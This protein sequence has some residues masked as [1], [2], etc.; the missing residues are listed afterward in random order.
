MQ[1]RIGTDLLVTAFHGKPTHPEQDS[2]SKSSKSPRLAQGFLPGSP[3]ALWRD[4]MLS[5]APHDKG[6]G[7]DFYF[8]T[9]GRNPESKVIGIADGVGGWEESG[10]C[11]LFLH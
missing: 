7:H 8:I 1:C 4:E 11:T 10:V 6:A 9:E 2:D 3:V 5:K